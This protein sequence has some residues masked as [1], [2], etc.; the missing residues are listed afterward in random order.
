MYMFVCV[1]IC[2]HMDVY[3]CVHVYVCIQM[4]LEARSHSSGAFP[5]FLRQTPS[6]VPV[7]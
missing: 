6:L 1:Y 3:A 7:A 5:M 4:H 2:I